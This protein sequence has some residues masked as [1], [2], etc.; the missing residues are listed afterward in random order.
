MLAAGA[1]IAS[2]TTAVDSS[3][4]DDT[5][6]SSSRQQKEKKRRNK[7]KG[8]SSGGG[9][10]GGG[11]DTSSS[12]SVPDTVS[13][14]IA[15]TVG[16]VDGIEDAQWR[17]MQALGGL[18]GVPIS[19][20]EISI[21]MPA[22]PPAVTLANLDRVAS[23]LLPR[24]QGG[25]LLRDSRTLALAEQL[26]EAC[27]WAMGA[28]ATNIPDRGLTLPALLASNIP[29]V[30]EKLLQLSG[31]SLRFAGSAASFLAGL[32]EFSLSLGESGRAY[33]DGLGTRCMAR[34]VQLLKANMG[35]RDVANWCVRLLYIWISLNQRLSLASLDLGVFDLLVD[36]LARSGRA[37]SRAQCRRRGTAI[38]FHLP[39]IALATHCSS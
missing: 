26:G 38:R 35:D 19:K 17:A 28:V 10:S 13:S 27:V 7:K 1:T 3:R 22:L 4:V 5:P 9:S 36:Q 25:Q 20:G 15:L 11:G 29:T 2:T 21:A 16:A 12:L 39:S 8:G 37:H 14:V 6:A 33:V 23:F 24:I 18:I 34:I 32:A 30:V 31:L